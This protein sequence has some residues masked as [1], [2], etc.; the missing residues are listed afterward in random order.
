MTEDNQNVTEDMDQFLKSIGLDVPEED[1]DVIKNVDKVP[2]VNPEAVRHAFAEQKRKLKIATELLKQSKEESGKRMVVDNAPIQ[3]SEATAQ[4]EAYASDLERRAINAVR[5]RGVNISTKSGKDLVTLELNRLYQ[6]DMQAM[7]RRALA[8]KN[9]VKVVGDV[10]GKFAD[11]DEDDKLAIVKD[12]EG[13]PDEYRANPDLVEDMVYRYRGRNFDKFV[14]KRNAPKKQE[15]VAVEGDEE[16]I[17]VAPSAASTA[18]RGSRGVSLAYTD[19]STPDEPSPPIKDMKDIKFMQ[20]MGLDPND[21]VDRRK[22][23]KAKQDS[24]LHRISV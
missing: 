2:G 18:S 8:G 20:K 17:P 5:S 4:A 23:R 3:M 19:T 16:Q 13:L 1:P 7:E 9:A 14:G 15:G 11:L 10:F 6:A 21:P 12:L 24:G 22:F